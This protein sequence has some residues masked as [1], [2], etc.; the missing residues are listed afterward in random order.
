MH[1]KEVQ[2][3]MNI[4]PYCGVARRDEGG[5]I[6]AICCPAST[7]YE[8]G[9]RQAAQVAIVRVMRPDKDNVSLTCREFSVMAEGDEGKECPCKKG[10]CYHCRAA[11]SVLAEEAGCKAETHYGE[12]YAV[13]AVRRAGCGKVLRVQTP[14]K[15]IFLA[16]LPLARPEPKQPQPQ[17]VQD[18]AKHCP[19]GAALTPD[20]L[21]SGL[22]D[23]CDRSFSPPVAVTALPVVKK[24]APRARKGNGGP[25]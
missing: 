19:C 17:P 21:E 10:I 16:L 4:L 12:Q 24:A 2:K 5:R 15:L 20:R 7:K 6:V 13:N 8:A 22:C 9:K 1:D 14:G 25:G 23:R 11:I 18:T 3:A